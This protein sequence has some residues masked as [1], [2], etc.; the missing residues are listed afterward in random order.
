MFILWDTSLRSPPPPNQSQGLSSNNSSNNGRPTNSNKIRP[1]SLAGLIGS[2]VLSQQSSYSP[3]SLAT[4]EARS[5]AEC[6]E[7]GSLASR[8]PSLLVGNGNTTTG[9]PPGLNKALLNRLRCEQVDSSFFRFF[10]FLKNMYKTNV[11]C[12]PCRLQKIGHAT[13]VE[14]P[15]VEKS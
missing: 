3:N 2:P 1:K 8:K 15:S 10:S 11:F 5:R 6:M 13:L 4:L 12:T 14:P 9:H 7:Y